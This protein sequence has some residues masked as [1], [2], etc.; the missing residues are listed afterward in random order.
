MTYPP[1]LLVRSGRRLGAGPGHQASAPEGLGRALAA[2]LLVVLCTALMVSPALLA[3]MWVVFAGG[4]V[5]QPA[6]WVEHLHG[7]P[8]LEAG[9][10]LVTVALVTKVTRAKELE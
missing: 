1:S 2:A 8:V 3:A 5:E 10:V 6:P 4:L 7:I 9:R